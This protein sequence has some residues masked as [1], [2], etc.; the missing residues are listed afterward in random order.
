M[1]EL[2]YKITSF[3]RI[4]AF[5]TKKNEILFRF[6]FC[7]FKISFLVLNYDFVKP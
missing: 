7:Q 2:L 5:L 1:F 4:C 3:F 6:F